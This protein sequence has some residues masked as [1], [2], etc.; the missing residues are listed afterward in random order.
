VRA[1]SLTTQPGRL[2][3]LV[4]RLPLPLYRAGWGW[5]F[6][7]RT[8]LVLTHVGRRSGQP[9][10]TAAMVLAEDRRT[11]EVVICSVWGPH[12]DWIRNLRAHPALRVQVGRT[13]FVPQHRFLTDEEAF[14]VGA[15]FRRRHPWRVR[16]LS[17]VLAADLRS[18]AGIRDF[19]ATRPC[20]A[21]QPLHTD[22]PALPGRSTPSPW[23]WLIGGAVLFFAV[24]FLGTDTFGLQP[25]LFYLGYFTVALLWFA[26]FFKTNRTQLHDLWR[27]NLV[28]SLAVGAVAGI[29]VAAIV[30]SSSATDHPEGWRWWFEIGWRG[31]VYGTVDALTLFVFPAALAYLLMHG[32]RSGVKRRIGY[33]ALVLALSL[34][35]SASY[36]LGYPEYRDAD[37]RSPL[38]GTV[39]G[40]SAAVLTGNPTGAFLTHGT[41]HLSAVVHQEEGGPTRMLPPRVTADYPHH[42]DS[43]LAAGL[44]ALWLVGAAGAVTVLARRQRTDQHV[45]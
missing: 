17:R 31:V 8:F 5:L 23:L 3:L 35:V 43:D 10:A 25:D 11:G 16:L 12:T 45:R 13:S 15:D 44:A 14:A 33:G 24:P 29:A 7:G 34:L 9:H 40:S 19:V 1:V 22:R 37:I 41:A 18:D 28:W 21:L 39:I 4:F 32:D 26:A 30:F 6:L 38:I 2:A 36:H 42:G 20:V 27:L